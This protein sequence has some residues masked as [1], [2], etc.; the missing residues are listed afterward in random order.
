MT[1]ILY[2]RR[3]ALPTRASYDASSLGT[4]TT[5]QVSISNPT[6]DVWYIGVYG[7][8]TYAGVTLTPTVIGTP[9]GEETIPIADGTTLSDLSAQSVPGS[10]TK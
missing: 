6:A 7:Y 8:G 2:A 4:F 5:E 1:R 10:T 3:G 9:G